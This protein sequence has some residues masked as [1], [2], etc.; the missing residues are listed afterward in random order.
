MRSNKIF[1]YDSIYAFNNRN[2]IKL[3]PD[4]RLKNFVSSF[5]YLAYQVVDFRYL[6]E[7]M[8]TQSYKK[9]RYYSLPDRLPIA[10]AIDRKF[11]TWHKQQKFPITPM[12]LKNNNLANRKLTKR[13]EQHVVYLIK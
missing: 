7:M 10:S 12:G 5:Y 2:S 1:T 4:Y 6:F 9:Y 3:Y 11:T 13:R 8:V